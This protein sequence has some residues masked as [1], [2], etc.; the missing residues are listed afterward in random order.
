VSEEPGEV[1]KKI[2]SRWALEALGWATTQEQITGK[3]ID[4][5]IPAASKDPLKF[6]AL[7][8]A[9]VPPKKWQSGPQAKDGGYRVYLSD[10]SKTRRDVLVHI[11]EPLLGDVFAF[12]TVNQIF[13]HL[14]IKNDY[15]YMVKVRTDE[16]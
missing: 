16:Q 14:G 1:S 2:K 3:S 8:N 5:D 12:S 9:C 4:A 10:S 15:E 13:E 7:A 6:Y 11:F